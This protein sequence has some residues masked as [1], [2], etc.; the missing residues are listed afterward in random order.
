MRERDFEAWIGAFLTHCALL[1][2]APRPRAY[3]GPPYAFMPGRRLELGSA[4]RRARDKRANQV[5]GW[6]HRAAS[7]GAN[8]GPNQGL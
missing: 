1:R 7:R 6:V 8:H 5:R 2:S 3:M 4:E